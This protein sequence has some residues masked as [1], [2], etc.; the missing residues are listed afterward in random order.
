MTSYQPENGMRID[1]A[2]VALEDLTMEFDRIDPMQTL[3]WNDASRD[4]D[5]VSD[6]IDVL[7]RP[8]AFGGLPCDMAR[9]ERLNPALPVM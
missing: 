3:S 9:S 2:P 6:N 8:D 1:A 4:W 7:G 5:D